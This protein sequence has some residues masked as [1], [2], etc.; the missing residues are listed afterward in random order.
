[1]GVLFHGGMQAAAAQGAAPAAVPQ[2]AQAA[3]PAAQGAAGA[4]GGQPA[5]GQVPGPAGAAGGQPAPGP[6]GQ[7][8][9]GAAA[10][11]MAGQ[12]AAAGPAMQVPV[13]GFGVF[14]NFPFGFGPP[15]QQQPREKVKLGTYSET[16]PRSFRTFRIRAEAAK[17][18]NQWSDADAKSQVKIALTGDAA[19]LAQDIEIGADP[20]VRVGG[21]PLPGAK[22]WLAY[23]NELHDRFVPL[24]ESQIAI[25]G[26]TKLRQKPGE[27][28]AE[29]HVRCKEECHVAYP[30]R[31]LEADP[32]LMRQF[33]HH[34]LDVA[35]STY[36]VDS[37]P[38]T[39][40]ECLT[41]AQ[42]KQGNMMQI[43]MAAKSR[44]G[45]RMTA[46]TFEEEDSMQMNAINYDIGTRTPS[47]K[48][49]NRL[50]RMRG[51]IDMEKQRTNSMRK[52]CS[53]CQDPTH[54]TFQCP[55]NDQIAAK[56]GRTDRDRNR[57]RNNNNGRFGGRN[58]KQGGQ[59]AKGGKWTSQSRFGKKDTRNRNKTPYRMTAMG[60]EIDYSDAL[61]RLDPYEEE[62]LANNSWANEGY[63]DESPARDDCLT[64][65][66]N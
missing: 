23:M 27:S 10:A 31:D 5:P 65:E 48:E 29:W 16:T 64:D 9:G 45:E 28:L 63:D 12:Q 8:A 22:T 19:S 46:M 59:A 62:Y 24:M 51:N 55:H 20:D 41:I 2:P 11:G 3:A 4:A 17:D 7:P 37:H 60:T 13:P 66:G 39:Y 15:Q 6:G 30:H 53:V 61:G 43:R 36:V 26:F 40:R 54:Q 32:E 58:S 44:H 1:M 50:L 57:N 34:I 47:S 49:A 52:S 33:M 18:L 35:V 25:A 38:R 42:T 56:R 21:M 14:P